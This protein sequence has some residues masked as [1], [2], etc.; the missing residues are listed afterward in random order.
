MAKDAKPDSYQLNLRLLTETPL[1]LPLAQ[2]VELRAAIGDMLLN[3]LS[4]P[5]SPAAEADDEPETHA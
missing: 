4:A 2:Q 5:E 3:A 1:T